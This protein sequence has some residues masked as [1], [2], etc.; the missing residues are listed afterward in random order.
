LGPAR[1]RAARRPGRRG[2]A[3]APARRSWLLLCERFY[4]RDSQTISG[5]TRR[6]SGDSLVVLVA[7]VLVALVIF[8][9]VALVVV[10]FVV[11][12]LVVVALVLVLI[13][14]VAH[15]SSPLVPARTACPG[16]STTMPGNDPVNE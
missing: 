4:V 6:W 13:P 3:W 5:P 14:V 7:L 9:V 10:A 11:V 12:A 1:E 15:L 16:L 2:L 8:V